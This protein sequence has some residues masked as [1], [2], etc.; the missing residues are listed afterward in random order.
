MENRHVIWNTQNRHWK[1]CYII[2]IFST[3]FY[4]CLHT[5]PYPGSR[6]YTGKNF[7]TIVNIF[8]QLIIVT[9]L[10][11]LDVFRTSAYVSEYTKWFIYG[12]DLT[13]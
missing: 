12:R 10:S 1:T 7:G 4:F 2:K 9:K 5:E 13:N 3:D 11:I 6:K 8:W